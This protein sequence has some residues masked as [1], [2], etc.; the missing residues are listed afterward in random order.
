VTWTGRDGGPPPVRVIFLCVENAGRSQMA[1]A[2]A[3]RERERRGLD[4]LV[5]LHSAGTHPAD[6]VSGAVV[7]AMGEVGLDVSDRTPRLLEVSE[8][9]AADYVVTMGCYVREFDPMRFGVD[10]REWD[11]PDPAGAPPAVVRDA[12]DEVEA[13]VVELFDDVEARLSDASRRT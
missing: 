7:D 13:R 4:D 3:E 9:E 2:F 8:L 6:A 10:A 12:R 5:E 11:L 1:T